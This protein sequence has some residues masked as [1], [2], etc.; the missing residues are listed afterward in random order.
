MK[1]HAWLSCALWVCACA[2][3]DGAGDGTTQAA[4]ESGDDNDTEAGEFAFS[5]AART[6]YVRSD[7]LGMPGVNTA[8]IASKDAYNAADPENDE[9]FAPEIV[10]AVEFLHSALDDDLD[11]AGLIPCAP[12]DCVAVAAPLVIP[13]V[14]TIDPSQP[15]GFPN[16]RRLAEPVLDVVIALLLLDLTEPGQTPTT[17]AELPLNPPANDVPFDAAFPYLAPPHVAP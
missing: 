5:T 2:G 8:V 1:R 12:A 13:D 4:S 11:A 3:D 9:D 15:S 16:G 14:I 6:D 10:A 7:R 17:L